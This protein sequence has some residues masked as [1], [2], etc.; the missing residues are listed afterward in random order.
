MKS[1]KVSEKSQKW[2]ENHLI[3]L[4]KKKASVLG[5]IKTDYSSHP[6]LIEHFNQLFLSLR[7]KSLETHGAFSPELILD[8]IYFALKK[9][10]GQSEKTAPKILI[11][12]TPC[13]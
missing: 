11:S 7:E 13:T 6:L 3:E 5:Q 9:H 4:A 8:A 12:S 10:L 1:P 2:H